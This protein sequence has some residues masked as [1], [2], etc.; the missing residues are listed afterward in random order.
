MNP[1]EKRGKV[2]GVGSR[3]RIIG[4]VPASSN[5]FS[6]TVL[7]SFTRENGGGTRRNEGL[8]RFRIESRVCFF[9]VFSPGSILDT[10]ARTKMHVCTIR[11]IGW[12][13][14]EA[15]SQA[16]RQGRVNRFVL[17]PFANSLESPWNRSAPS[18]WHVGPRI[19]TGETI[20]KSCSLPLDGLQ[21]NGKMKHRVG[22]ITFYTESSRFFVPILAKNGLYMKKR[23]LFFSKFYGNNNNNNKFRQGHAF[24]YHHCINDTVWLLYETLGI[25]TFYTESN[26]FSKIFI[27]FKILINK[28]PIVKQHL[29]T[30]I[31]HIWRG[32][33]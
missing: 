25:I 32:T 8:S 16:N 2:R 26:K 5:W 1:W 13:V 22:V 24:N 7:F 17:V 3:V 28:L 33:V 31:T 12:L 18:T 27:L 11:R 21:H 4:R 15:V 10:F 29:I 19:E 9:A 14:F 20:D 6:K 30:L 23:F